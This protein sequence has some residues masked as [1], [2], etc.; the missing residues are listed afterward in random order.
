MT[1][2]LGIVALV[3]A[4]LVSGIAPARAA[5]FV[6]TPTALQGWLVFNDGLTTPPTAAFVNGPATPPLGTGSYGT[7]ITAA[8]NKIAFGRND[9]AY[10]GVL[11]SSLT[12]LSYST[13][14]NP[15]STRPVNWYINVYLDTTGTGTTYNFRLDYTPPGST[16][17]IWQ[18]WNTLSA[19]QPHW[20]LFN[21]STGTYTASGSYATVTAGLPA[22]TRVINAFNTVPAYHS[23]KFSMGDGASS[24][25]G[26]VGNIDNITINFAGV[27]DTTWDLELDDPTP[28][29]TNTPTETLTPTATETQTPT[30]T[31]TETL[32][33]SLTSTL[34]QT[35]S[36][37]P[38]ETLSPTNTATETL[39]P[40]ST[41]TSTLNPTVTPSNTPTN[42]A[43][44]TNTPTET[45][46]PTE[47]VIFTSTPSNT[48]T[49]TA[50]ITSTP[51]N[52]PTNTAVITNT[53][54][55]TA[56]PTPTS[57]ATAPGIDTPTPTAS[58]TVTTAPTFGPSP[59]ATNTVAVVPSATPAII[60]V[61][62]VISKLAS[63]G[64]LLPGEVV[65]FTI[66]ATNPGSIAA[67]NVVVVDPLPSVFIVRGAT[68]TQGAFTIA[69][70]TV[71]F[72][73][74]TLAPGQ[75]VTMTVTAQV[76]P[77]AQTPQD[78]TNVA[79]LND[80]RGIQRSA[81]A[82]V[83]IT[84]GRLPATGERPEDAGATLRWLLIGGVGLF[85]LAAL[86]RRRTAPR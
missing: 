19:A 25:V 75:A 59:S 43:V 15:A 38:T 17:G 47:T 34:T 85:V 21:R 74:G 80:G 12:A 33:P 52:T 45:P 2:S 82:T 57:S 73:I 16:T 1:R 31:P 86:W 83:R 27:S 77:A 32:T 64:I 42:T 44:I 24:Y 55:D 61:D 79:T 51:S 13:Y 66:T 11:L 22:G 54:T 39:T 48:P 68:T 71:T 72:T 10:N 20:L 84:A 28:T 8:A 5:T 53:P 40:T 29:P 62:P 36:N 50:V 14:V 7:S 9:P 35:P 58:P 76:D 4:F 26:Y 46:T 63:S 70:N 78:V 6:V 65:T 56:S 23:I 37:T 18:T 60:V 49:N 81:A 67:P 41:E 3:L 69:G 30:S